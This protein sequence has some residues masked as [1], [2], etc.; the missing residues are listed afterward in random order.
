[1]SRAPSTNTRAVSLSVCTSDR[2]EAEGGPIVS[3]IGGN[4]RDNRPW[5]LAMADA[6]RAVKLGQ[7][8]FFVREG[9]RRRLLT[10]G[11]DAA[12][13]PCLVARGADGSDLLQQ[14]PATAEQLAA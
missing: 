11:T 7:Y 12:G 2:R 13:Q 6:L 9:E 4:Y 10:M 1:M 3:H 5:R 8:A 14:L